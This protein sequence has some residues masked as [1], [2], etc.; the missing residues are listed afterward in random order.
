MARNDYTLAAFDENGNER[1]DEQGALGSAKAAKRIQQEPITDVFIMSHGWMG[2]IQ[3]A[4]KQ[5]NAWTD[6]MLANT[7]DLTRL[8]ALRPGFKPLMLGI[9]WPSKPWGDEQ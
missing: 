9:H 5:Y 4:L 1:Q 8:A 6:A 7:D 3:D 2:D